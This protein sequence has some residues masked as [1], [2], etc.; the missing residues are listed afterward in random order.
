MALQNL[1]VRCWLRYQHQNIHHGDGVILSVISNHASGTTVGVFQE[2]DGP[3]GQGQSF[4][5]LIGTLDKND[6]ER[7]N[8]TARPQLAGAFRPRGGARVGARF[9]PDI[10]DAVI[11]NFSPQFNNY[12]GGLPHGQRPYVL[13]TVVCRT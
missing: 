8:T 3:G 10:A 7:L 1:N 6:V 5:R 11:S 13:I 9:A 2:D 12:V 4:L